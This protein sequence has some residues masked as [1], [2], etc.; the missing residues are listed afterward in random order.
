ML[1]RVKV[2]VA[3]VGFCKKGKPVERRGRKISGL[4]GACP[5]TAGLPERRCGMVSPSNGN[6]VSLGDHPRAKARMTPQETASVLRGCRYL[7]LDRLARALSTM[8]DRVE[9]DLFTLA[10]GAKDSD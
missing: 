1:V 10:E 5:T 3:R 7:A 9:E 4:K 2:R 6:V 8:L